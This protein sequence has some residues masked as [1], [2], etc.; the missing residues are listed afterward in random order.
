MKRQIQKRQSV[1]R[2]NF[3]KSSITLNIDIM[4]FRSPEVNT[5]NQAMQ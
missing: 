4:C 1:Y 5:G 2:I 3:N